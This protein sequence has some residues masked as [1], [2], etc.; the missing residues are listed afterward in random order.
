[1]LSKPDVC[2]D[3]LS[4]QGAR[5]SGRGER[6]CAQRSLET[7]LPPWGRHA[8]ATGVQ[9]EAFALVFST[10]FAQGWVR[11]LRSAVCRQR[12]CS[13]NSSAL[14]WSMRVAIVDFRNHRPTARTHCTLQG[15]VHSQGI[16]C[17]FQFGSRPG[18]ATKHTYRLP[19]ATLFVLSGFL[20]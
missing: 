4:L 5:R 18:A 14:S 12:S 6:W 15:G 11:G 2:E 13:S 9:K 8:V 7:S 17:A 1:M 3:R 20:W 10:C 16:H 19:R